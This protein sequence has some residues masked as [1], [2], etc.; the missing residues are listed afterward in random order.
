[1]NAGSWRR[2]GTHASEGGGGLGGHGWSEA[3]VGVVRTPAKPP[4]PMFV[5]GLRDKVYTD[6]PVDRYKPALDGTT[7]PDHVVQMVVD[8]LFEGRC[9]ICLRVYESIVVF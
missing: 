2:A 3:V 9:W 1:M 6:R 7:R 8:G 4:S 5:S